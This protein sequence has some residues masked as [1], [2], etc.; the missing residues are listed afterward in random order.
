MF[1][2]L[3]QVLSVSASPAIEAASEVTL[4][5]SCPKSAVEKLAEHQKEAD[6]FRLLFDSC[7]TLTAKENLLHM[8][9]YIRFH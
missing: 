3:F 5:V 4:T 9:R 6:D 1:L 2:C 7:K 8:M